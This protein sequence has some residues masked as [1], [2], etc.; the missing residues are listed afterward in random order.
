MDQ[1]CGEGVAWGPSQ[2]Q[3]TLESRFGFAPCTRREWL[4]PAQPTPQ[5]RWSLK[6]AS[7]K[8]AATSWELE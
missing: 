3:K 2:G 4:H 5:A 6:E 8:M 7:M 1:T